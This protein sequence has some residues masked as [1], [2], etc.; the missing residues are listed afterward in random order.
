M[1]DEEF[2]RQVDAALDAKRIAADEHRIALHKMA[3][4]VDAHMQR[5][6]WDNYQ[7]NKRQ[8]ERREE[9]E[10]NTLLDRIL[11]EVLNKLG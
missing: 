10:T 2:S 11:E 7:A 3:L 4:E 1:T 5:K 8:R 9:I 6:A